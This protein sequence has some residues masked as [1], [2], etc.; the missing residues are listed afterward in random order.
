LTV[1]S[2]VSKLGPGQVRSSYE[3]SQ[4]LFLVLCP[5]PQVTEQSVK[6]VH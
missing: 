5:T 1:Q 6:A 3:F 4:N 2:T